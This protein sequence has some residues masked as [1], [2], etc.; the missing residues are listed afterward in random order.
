MVNN[1]KTEGKTW[2]S[3]VNAL[4]QLNL[5]YDQNRKQAEKNAR[6]A[7]AT[8]ECAVCGCWVYTGKKTLEKANIKAPE[9]VEIKHQHKENGKVIKHKIDHI[10]PF[11]PITG[12]RDIFQ[13]FRML[14]SELEN[15]QVM[16]NDCHNIKS[17]EE[18]RFRREF[19]KIDQDSD[20][21][22]DLCEEY[23]NFMLEYTD[24]DVWDF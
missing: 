10:V 15:Y 23:E 11:R 16:C 9:G 2:T 14:F 17:K 22:N 5:R 7:P 6:V 21:W 18:N 19:K 24:D 8:Y 12:E 3:F 20:E 1:I 13:L 4:R